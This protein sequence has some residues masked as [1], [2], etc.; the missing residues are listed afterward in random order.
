MK[1]LNRQNTV[2]FIGLGQMG[3]PM[4]ENLLKKGHPLVVY[5]IDPAKVERFVSLGALASTGPTDVARRAS[6]VVSMVD[7][8]A[9]AQEVITGVNGL[10]PGAQSGDVVISMS[11]IEPLALEGMRNTLLKNGVEIIDAPV[12][13]M[14]KGAREGTLRAFVGGEVSALDNARPVL[15][16]MCGEIIHFG[17]I[18]KGTTMKLVNNMLMQAGRVLVAEAMALGAKAGLDTA[19][20]VD[21]IRRS[22]GN[23]VVFEYSAPRMVERNFQGIRMD[24]TFKDLELQTQLGKALGVPMF[25]ATIAQQIYQMARASG[26]G[27]ED[28]SAV[29]KIYEKFMGV[30]VAHPESKD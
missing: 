14:E 26:L 13:G 25:M 29:I 11:T 7:T 28:P 19:Q 8:T 4:A 16:S 2:G 10:L 1:S 18:G 3:A 30:S 17:A 5:D 12:S 9:Q 6:R 22:T 24:I 23:S 15:E 21:V 20:M 27:H